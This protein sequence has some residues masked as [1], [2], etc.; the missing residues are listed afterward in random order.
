M[1]TQK[2]EYTNGKT[3]FIGHLVWD[4]TRS[5][6]LP[7]IVVFPEAFGLNDHARQKAE[8]LA[9]LGYVALAADPHGEGAVY[10]D[11]ATLGPKMQALYAD[12]AEWRSRARAALNA[13][14]AQPQVDSGRTAAIGFCFGGTTCFELA[15]DG[16]PL[17]A[18]ATFHAGLVPG[19]PED[20]GRIHAKV[21]V[22]H[23]AEDPLVKKEVIDA[24][25]AELRRDKVDWQFIYHGNTGH[26]FTDREADK[27]NMPG[28][29]YN[30][31]A[32]ERSWAAMRCVFDEAFAD[33]V[34]RS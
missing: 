15:R 1:R 31:A 4:D 29:G 26:S 18:I 11:M 16:A 32:E 30:G 19:L 27:R 34:L 3:K 8:R 2:I 13:L 12:R 23:G 24:V 14:V 17:S 22:C 25:M 5:G 28:F 10:S 7:G 20:A 6:R 33:E 21:L 9:Q